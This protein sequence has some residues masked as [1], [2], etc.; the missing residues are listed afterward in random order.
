[1]QQYVQRNVE[2]GFELAMRPA[3]TRK[4]MKLDAKK[5]VEAH[6]KDGNVTILLIDSERINV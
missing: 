5:T 4:L 6:E 2:T 3:M 1:M